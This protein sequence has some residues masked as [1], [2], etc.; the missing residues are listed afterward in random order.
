MGLD[1]LILGGIYTINWGDKLC[2]II[3]M[4]DDE[5]FYDCLLSEKFGWTF[6]GHFKK[7]CYFYRVSRT[8]FLENSV[9]KDTLPLTSKE[10]SVFRPDLPLRIGRT[11]KL[12]WNSHKEDTYTLFLKNIHTY[13]NDDFIN[14]TL[15]IR[16][17]FLAPYG[18]KNGIYKGTKI[19]SK[20]TYFDVLELIWNAKK[21]QESVNNEISNGIGIFRLG[22][23]DYTPSFYIGEYLD[24]AGILKE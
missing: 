7:K 18:K 12:S 4:D 9:Y 2:R 17:I 6:S 21:L 11:T 15:E 5:I 8:T 1:N 10:C 13:E 3:G 22:F 16:S 20:S 19:E 14:K 23:Q 24:N